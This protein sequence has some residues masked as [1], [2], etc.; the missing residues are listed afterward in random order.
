MTFFKTEGNKG[1]IQNR[2]LADSRV[3]CGLLKCNINITDYL[4]KQDNPLS[5]LISQYPQI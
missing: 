4:G 2:N 3:C 5:G 1:K